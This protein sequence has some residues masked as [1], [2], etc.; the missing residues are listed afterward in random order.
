MHNINLDTALFEIENE[1]LCWTIRD[2][3]EGVQI[4]G[5]IGS[6]KTSGSGEF[7]AS[8]FLRNGF[9]G[10]VLTV[11]PDE[12][13]LWERYCSNANRTEDLIIVEPEGE[14]FFNFLEYE[15]E[16]KKFNV[17]ITENIVQVLK[18]VIRASDDKSS[19]KKDDPFWEDA[20]D[21]LMFRIIDLCLLSY[22]TVT[23]DLLYSIAL[24]LP[25][26][27]VAADLL[28]KSAD[29]SNAFK[30]A[31][32]IAKDKAQYLTN[33]WQNNLTTEK[34]AGLKT[35][36][37]YLHALY[38]DI[39]EA[40]TFGFIKQFFIDNYCE[41]NEK[42]RS[43][44][45]FSFAGF[46]MRMLSEPIYSL[47]CKKSYTFTPEDSINGKI[48]LINLPVKIY[49]KVGR[50]I[51]VMFK[52]IWQRAMERR[53]IDENGRP[54][55]LWADEAQNF[56][57]EHDAD[58]Q[59]TARSSRVATVYLTQNIPNYYANMGGN[60]YEHKVRSFLGTLGTKIFH[61]NADTITNNYASDL[62]GQLYYKKVSSSHSFSKEYS[63]SE[64]ESVELKKRVRP[65][66]F[67]GLKSG[68][69]YNDK[70]VEAIV[71][72]QSKKFGNGLSHKKLGFK[73]S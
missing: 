55:F 40:R 10:L 44:I 2:A 31:Y 11:K 45:D 43:I 33:Q 6:G 47:F 39:P 59:A 61:A 1:K 72:L 71:F 58:Y 68:G 32:I 66:E 54:V 53:N 5:G 70:K 21:M 17:A 7:L 69:D 12:K 38:E 8:K 20:L 73:Q 27:K 23:V 15:S 51:Q 49:D 67:I 34:L 62:I 36:Q 13:T 64:S 60:K 30:T 16:P 35:K 57:H 22:G 48:I 14:H 63:T 50:D 65:E 19:G 42:T 3:V 25:H 26:S 9:G 41:L 18:T 4:F 29:K 28:F 37:Q 56:L 46:I 52:Y 24:S